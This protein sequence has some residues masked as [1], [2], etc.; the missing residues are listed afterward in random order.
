MLQDIL[1]SLRGP[2]RNGIKIVGLEPSCVAVFR[3]EIQRFFRRMARRLTAQTKTWL[4]F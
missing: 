4:N 1:I 2:V 3:D